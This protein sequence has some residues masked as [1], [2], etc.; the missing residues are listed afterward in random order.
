M[1]WIISLLVLCTVF[2]VVGSIVGG[3]A[4]L[5]PGLHPN[6]IAALLAGFPQLFAMFTV[7]NERG[8]L[9]PVVASSLFLGCFLIG[10][11]MG[12]SLTEII[13]TAM[14]GISDDETVI[15][16]L[17]S[18]RLYRLGRSDLVIEAAVIGGIGSVA[19]F[20]LLFMPTR[21]IM[22]EPVG[23]YSSIKHFMAFLLL[24]IS[25]FVL[26]SSRYQKRLLLSSISFILSGII[27]LM[28]LTMQ[29]PTQ[30][31]VSIFGGAWPGDSSTFLLPAFSGFFAI[32]ALLFSS[33]DRTMINANFST[34]ERIRAPI[35]RPM[36]RSLVSSVL[37]GWI[38]GITNAYATSL[39]T[40]RRRADGCSIESAYQYL[41]T[42]TA[43]NV[44]GSLQSIIAMA[45]IFRA[46]NGT[47]EAINDHF[48][49][50]VLGWFQEFEPPMTIIAFIWAACIAA[51]TGTW[52]C[53]LFGRAL[54]RGSTGR[55]FR[56]VRTVIL[57]FILLLV[58]WT[59]GPM[60]LIVLFS[61]S[62]LGAWTIFKGAPRVHLMGFLLVP[63]IVYFLF[64]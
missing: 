8:A 4:G 59:S 53:M 46:R 40:H 24:G 14:L 41:V 29:I 36:L 55:S 60:G 22:G 48:S 16:Q 13:P 54:L 17:P 18:Q 12:H 30:L 38:P 23:L 15:A 27:G 1:S 20:A 57:L 31:T 5:V 50:G 3:I 43:T 39:T 64:N 47:L 6:S 7:E 33:G 10:V 44:G 11:L 58:L 51:V 9:D 62:T 56:T 45:T 21:F 42:Y 32:P 19:L 2:S 26:L 49:T 61:C 52:L 37:V 25:V 63:V 34:G 28:V 35:G